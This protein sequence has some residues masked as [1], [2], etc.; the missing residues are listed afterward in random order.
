M[1]ESAYYPAGAYNDPRAPYNQPDPDECPHCHGTGVQYYACDF[2]AERDIPCTEATWLGLYADEEEARRNG[3]H[4]MRG[5]RCTCHH[6][7]GSGYACP[8]DEYADLTDI[9]DDDRYDVDGY[10][11][12]HICNQYL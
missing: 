6:C 10:K 1:S 5:E 11:Y 8:D 7:G 4:V 12:D 9:D 3:K 2:R